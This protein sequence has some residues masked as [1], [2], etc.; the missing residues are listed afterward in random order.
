LIPASQSY[1]KNNKPNLLILRDFNSQAT[2]LRKSVKIIMSRIL[3]INTIYRDHE[4]DRTSER[5]LLIFMFLSRIL[6]CIIVVYPLFCIVRVHV[7]KCNSTNLPVYSYLVEKI[8]WCV[9]FRQHLTFFLFLKNVRR[10]HHLPTL[11]LLGVIFNYKKQNT[12]FRSY[13][14]RGIIATI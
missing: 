2:V 7:F 10:Y 9:L 4:S 14:E 6:Q 13:S 3:Y 5:H 8:Q 12:H 1:L 11:K